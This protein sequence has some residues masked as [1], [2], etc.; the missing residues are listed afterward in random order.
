MESLSMLDA[1]LVERSE[2]RKKE[3]SRVYLIWPSA[4]VYMGYFAL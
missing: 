3:G 2:E 1:A 4:L